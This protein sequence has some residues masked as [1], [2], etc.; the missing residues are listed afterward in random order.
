MVEVGK[1]LQ[2][3]EDG[4]AKAAIVTDLFGKSGADLLPFFN[5]LA[6]NVDDF[7]TTSAE[8]VAQASAL[9]DKMGMLGVRTN[10]V[11]TS[12]LTAAL[13]AMTDLADGFSDVLKAEDG[14]VNSGEIASWAD[15]LAVGL[16][17]VADVAVLLPRTFSA[18]SSS[19]K[20]VAADLDLAWAATP[21]NMARKLLSGG[22]PLQDIKNAAAERNAILEDANQK[23]DDLWNKPANQ[24]EQAVM[25][26][27]A[28]RTGWRT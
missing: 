21:A 8:A 1:R 9:Q 10:E 19:F 27:I 4:A 11:F 17:R 15:D 14:L 7:S 13:P 3:Y 24:F 18:V 16:A 22:S 5:D 26:R 6:D 2:D 12:I 20:V 23:Y 28:S 25:K